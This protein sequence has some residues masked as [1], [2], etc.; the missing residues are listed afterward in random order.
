MLTYADVCC[1]PSVSP[2]ATRRKEQLRRLRS[3]I[4]HWCKGLTICKCNLD[5]P[6]QRF[7][8][9][10]MASY[11]ACACSRYSVYLLYWYKS[12]NTDFQKCAMASY[13]A[14][15]CCRSSVY[16]L[17]WYKSTNTDFQKCAMASYVACACSR[18]SVYLLYWYKS[19]NIDFQKCAMTSHVA[20]ACSRICL[21]AATSRCRKRHR[22]VA[23][24][25]CRMLTYA[26][27]CCRM[28]PYA[29]VC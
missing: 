4:S 6:S 9:C 1:A 14:C 13:V 8:K 23:A 29:A 19:T 22:H 7:L 5:H 24:V 27:V 10:A 28:L 11:V 26:A 3:I 16:L 12:T 20:Y 18:Y 2:Q 25:C 17:Y 21:T 15:A